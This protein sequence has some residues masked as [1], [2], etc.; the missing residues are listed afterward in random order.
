MTPLDNYLWVV[1]KDKYYADNPETIDALK[2]NTREAID[3]IQLH[4]YR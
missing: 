2:D 3:E 4:I 1:V